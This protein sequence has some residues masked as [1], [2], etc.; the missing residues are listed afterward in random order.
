MDADKFDKIEIRSEEDFRAWMA[1]HHG[2][3]ASIWLVTWKAAH[4]DKY[5]SRDEVLDVLIAYGWIDGRRM[6][7]DD[8]RT[9]QLVSPRREQRWAKTYKDRAARLE[10]EGKMADP[11]RRAIADSKKAGLWDAL[12]HVD[13][14]V[15]PDDLLAAL[16]AKRALDWWRGAAPSYR[17]NVLRRMTTAKKAE[18]RAK[19]I[20]IISDAAA[21]GKKVPQY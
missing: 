21:Q 2:Q 9:M 20:G 3:E 10:A 16:E 6:K 15:E 19:R 8:D 18:T 7:L 17:R 14:L 11:G 1:A 5:V 13:D 4:R 12:E